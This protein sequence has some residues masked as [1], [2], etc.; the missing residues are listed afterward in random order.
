MNALELEGSTDL[1]MLESQDFRNINESP[2]THNR[3]LQLHEEDHT[4]NIYKGCC[5]YST[6]KR[7]LI[8]GTQIGLSSIIV[9]WCA[10]MIAV[11][12][13]DSDTSLEMSLISSILSYWFGRSNELDKK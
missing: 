9:V 11:K 3:I 8:L 7:L 4:D 12:D 13:D 1:E 6:D 10:T 2:R 5:D